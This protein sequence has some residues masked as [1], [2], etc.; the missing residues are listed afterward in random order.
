MK[1][2]AIDIGAGTEDV[3]LYDSV[4]ENVENCVKMV[5]PSPCQVFA[6]KVREATLQ[7]SDLFV[8]GDTIGGGPFAHALRMHVTAGFRVYMTEDAAYTVRNSLNQVKKLGIEIVPASG[9]DNFGGETIILEEV[10]IDKLAAFLKFFGEP[11]LDIDFVAIAVQDHG[12]F[13]EEMSNRQFR[14]NKIRELLEKNPRPEAFAF[15]EN[16][17][18]SCYPRMRSALQASK[19]QLPNAQVLVMDTSPDAILGCL[20]DAAVEGVD[21][22]LAVNVGNGHTMAAIISEDE[23]T[24]VLEHHTRLLNPQKMESLLRDFADGK[25]SNEQVF[26]DNGHGMFYLKKPPGFSEIKKVV[27]TGPNRKIL[28]ETG[29]PVHFA[30]PAGDVMMSGP[31]GLVEAT[32]RT[33]L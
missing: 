2:L 26:E 22:I 9:P 32:K 17:I 28:S 21:P 8:K 27:V 20:M 6:A 23:I 11:F 15:K 12:V 16:E 10:N 3:L 33:L 5:L 29:I 4:L 1:I 31:I 7:G 13:P 14:I 24:A 18:P 30:T 25:L 19:R